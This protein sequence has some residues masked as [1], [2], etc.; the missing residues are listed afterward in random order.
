[1]AQSRDSNTDQE[2][3]AAL[4]RRQWE[5]RK[6]HAHA[7]PR[8]TTDTRAELQQ[9]LGNA[10]LQAILNRESTQAI[11]IYLRHMLEIE[12]KTGLSTQ[13]YLPWNAASSWC[14]WIEPYYQVLSSLETPEELFVAPSNTPT[15]STPVLSRDGAEK[16]TSDDD[17]LVDWFPRSCGWIFV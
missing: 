5:N 10:R 7:P 2:T 14:N 8:A 12:A 17:F 15:E 13:S 4:L 11:D 3:A 9:V 16:L 6:D 1:M